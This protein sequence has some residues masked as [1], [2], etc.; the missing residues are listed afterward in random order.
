MRAVQASA[1]LKPIIE[2]RN[3]EKKLSTLAQNTAVSEIS[4][5]RTQDRS[6]ARAR[7]LGQWVARLNFEPCF[8]WA[9]VHGEGL[10]FKSGPSILVGLQ[11]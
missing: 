8:S 11:I 1:S 6:W 4:H 10:D 9:D 2:K 5:E 7:R 3:E